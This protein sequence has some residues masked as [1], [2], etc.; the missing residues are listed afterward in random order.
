[1]ATVSFEA[2]SMS[3]KYEFD[4]TFVPKD[5]S[6]LLTISAVLDKITRNDSKYN[7]KVVLFVSED[8]KL[9]KHIVEFG[10]TG[11]KEYELKSKEDRN[12]TVSIDAAYVAGKYIRVEITPKVPVQA[13]V[14]I[15]WR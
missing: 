5:A 1:M 12:P 6:G 10:F 2:I 3:S 15:T 14:E 7:I 9:W 4:D 8:R 11:N 13:G